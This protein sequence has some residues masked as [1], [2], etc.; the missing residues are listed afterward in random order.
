M[1]AEQDKS[2]KQTA[3]QVSPE[4][5]ETSNTHKGFLMF[6]SETGTE[7]GFWAFQDEDER[8]R[9]RDDSE[10]CSHCGYLRDY[11]ENAHPEARLEEMQVIPL[12]DAIAN[13]VPEPCLPSD[14]KWKPQ[15]P[16]GR[17]DSKGFHVL[18][19]GDELTIYD[20]EDLE[21]VVWEGVISLTPF[22][23]GKEQAFGMWIHNDQQ[24]MDRETWAKWFMDM[25]PAKL[26]SKQKQKIVQITSSNILH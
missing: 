23:V 26:V 15:F 4:N 14:H 17:W 18:K 12:R 25:N 21:K 8:F 1:T 22:T 7:G 24:G 13:K 2:N 20:K 5:H 6:F 10:V 16:N 11:V 9:V 19:N 3:Q